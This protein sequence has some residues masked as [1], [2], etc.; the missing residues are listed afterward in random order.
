MNKKT[1]PLLL[2]ALFLTLAY[3][4]CKKADEV[5][6]VK[7]NDAYFP[8]EIGKWVIY[9]VDSTLWDDF[10]CVKIVRR[11]Q[12]MYTVVDTFTDAK[13]RMSY[14]IDTR[15][16]KKS[17]DPWVLHSVIQATNTGEELEIVQDQLRMIKMVYP[18]A[19]QKKWEGNAYIVTQD[20][21]YFKYKGWTYFYFNVDK[22]FDNGNVTY[23]NTVSVLA[24]DET[25][26][27]PYAQPDE[28]ATRTYGKEVFAKGIGMVYR[29][30]YRW[31]YDASAPNNN[32]PHY[33]YT[34]C[35][36]GDGV[37]MRAVDHN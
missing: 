31:T 18:I 10:N 32:N 3:T 23:N 26:N 8:L 20:S 12:M 27:D 36:R 13:G 22:P 30:Y 21:D 6:V 2:I 24:I 17:E 11:Y 16:R 9:N 35:L 19:D 15:I 29:E 5:P 25:I 33:A 34:R 37:I 14:R 28:N 4:S 1:L 7:E